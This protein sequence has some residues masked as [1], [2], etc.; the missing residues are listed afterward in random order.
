VL[1]LVQLLREVRPLL[2]VDQLELVDRADLGIRTSRRELFFQVIL[3]R[4][5]EPSI[6]TS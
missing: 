4:S 3:E 2:P 5:G 6:A 1:A